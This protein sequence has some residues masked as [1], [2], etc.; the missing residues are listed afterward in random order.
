MNLNV[1]SLSLMYLLAACIN[2]ASAVINVVRPRIRK[3]T[4]I[5]SL[6]LLS[7]GIRLL[8]GFF[9]TAVVEPVFKFTFVVM[10]DMLSVSYTVLIFYFST[11]Y[12]DL[13]A[14]FR[15]YRW[16]LWI[17]V[18]L[19]AFLESN[20]RSSSLVLDIVHAGPCGQ[21]RDFLSTRTLLPGCQSVFSRL[22]FGIIIFGLLPFD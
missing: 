7:V 18:V 9:E 11:D 17:P 4:G 15:P 21:Q 14:W 5:L 13:W 22:A 10:E 16:I 2:L 12:F 20:Q 8:G 19:N 1:T 6:T 3:G